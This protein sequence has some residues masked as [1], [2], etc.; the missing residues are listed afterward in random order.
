MADEKK[1]RA[2]TGAPVDVIEGDVTPPPVMVDDVGRPMSRAKRPSPWPEDRRHRMTMQEAIEQLWPARKL[3]NEFLDLLQRQVALE[4]QVKDLQANGPAQVAIQHVASLRAELV[5]ADGDAGIV[6][7]LADTVSR[8]LEDHKKV[9]QAVEERATKADKFVRKVMYAAGSLVGGSI[10]A[11]VVLIYQAGEHA[12]SSKA[13][14]AAARAELV[15][16][17]DSLDESLTDLR[18]QVKLLLEA[19]INR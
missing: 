15:H 14:A 16:K 11:A 5:G 3:P 2:Q 19:R 10:I 4:Q 1:K 18:G 12:A 9:V 13:D 17:I 7:H 6:G 8:D